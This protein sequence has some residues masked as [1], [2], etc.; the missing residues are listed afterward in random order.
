MAFDLLPNENIM[1]SA[2][3]QRLSASLSGTTLVS[4]ERL[5]NTTTSK[6]NLAHVVSAAM[7]IVGSFLCS[8]LFDRLNAEIQLAVTSVLSS[9]AGAC[10]PFTGELHGYIILC[11]VQSAAL[12]YVISGILGSVNLSLT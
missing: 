12:A 5:L 7:W 1:R 4:L 9:V 10:S 8:A 2:L 3:V 6:I 11:G